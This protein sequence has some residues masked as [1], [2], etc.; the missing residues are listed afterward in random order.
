MKELLKRV[1]KRRKGRKLTSHDYQ[2][3]CWKESLRDDPR[4]AWKHRIGG[5]YVWSGDAVAHLASY[6]DKYYDA[7]KAEYN[8]HLRS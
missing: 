3:I 1:N 2:A 4:Y 5:S 7:I 8:H 6:D